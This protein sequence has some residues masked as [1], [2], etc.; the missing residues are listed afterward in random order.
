M[1]VVSDVD[2]GLCQRGV[3]F[4]AEG[5]EVVGIDFCSSVSSDEDV[6][7]ADAYFRYESVSFRVFG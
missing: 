1:G 3:I 4:G 6:V 5:S 2:S 7:E